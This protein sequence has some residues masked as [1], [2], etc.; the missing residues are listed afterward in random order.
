MMQLFRIKDRSPLWPMCV[1]LLMAASLAHAEPSTREREALRRAQQSL[2]AAQ[3]EREA[4]VGEKAALATD[5]TKL[6]GELKQVAAKVRGAESQA[7]GLKARVAQLEASLAEQQ[8][9]VADGQSRELAL[10][11]QLKQGEGKLAEQVRV[12]ATVQALLAER[13][14]E[15]QTLSAQNQAMYKAGLEAIELYRAQ[16]PSAFLQAR[17]KVLGWES[18]KLENVAETLRDRMD[19]ARY[20][21]L[22]AEAT[23]SGRVN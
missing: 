20:K 15:A 13:T 14:R 17:D 23:A 9:A 16:S 19:D 6:E 22:P 5:K 11:E 12:V 21:P 18:V 7:A 8:K 4:I 10:A 3:E 1:A 2:R